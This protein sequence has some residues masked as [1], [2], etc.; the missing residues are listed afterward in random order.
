MS[1]NHPPPFPY[2]SVVVSNNDWSYTAGDFEVWDGVL[3]LA[4]PVT[5]AEPATPSAGTPGTGWTF[6]NSARLGAASKAAGALT[7]T[8]DSTSTTWNNSTRDALG[9]IRTLDVVPTVGERVLVV[10]KVALSGAANNL[11]QAALVVYDT[12]DLSHYG[13]VGVMYTGSAYVADNRD[14]AGT[15]T[16]PSLSQAEAWVGVE[17]AA[18]RCALYYADDDGDEIP[19]LT[20]IRYADSVFGASLKKR[21]GFLTVSKGATPSAVVSHLS[22]YR[23]SA[24]DRPYNADPLQPGD[25]RPAF[26]AVA[27]LYAT[28]G[29]VASVQIEMPAS[30][31][32][33]AAQLRAA[34]RAA[35]VWC[36]TG[37]QARA[38]RGAA[39]SGAFATFDALTLEA[40]AGS[41]LYLDIQMTSDG[42]RPLGLR[43]L[44]L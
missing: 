28:D 17:I 3:Y 14:T 1:I 32:V 18:D 13:R 42:Y 26:G 35:C 19:T 22:V 41:D 21:I 7:L 4:R 10:A 15:T 37:M 25:L 20:Q 40:G 44:V 9:Y 24:W 38:R 33:T 23:G 29:P 31:V 16:N 36:S 6:I 27:D 43:A 5:F 34:L 30:K 8:A 39:P 12:S 2:G 11:E